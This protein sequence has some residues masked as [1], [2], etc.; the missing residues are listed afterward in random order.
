MKSKKNEFN[1]WNIVF[2]HLHKFV[3]DFDI[4]YVVVTVSVVMVVVVVGLQIFHLT[5]LYKLS[6]M[7]EVK[8]HCAVFSR[9]VYI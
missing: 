2:L 8:V 6:S 3:T 5:E 4:L 1:L 7:P 9:T